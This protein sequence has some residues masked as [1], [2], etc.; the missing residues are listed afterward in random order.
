M[1]SK[2]INRHYLI[3]TRKIIK[4][5]LLLDNLKNFR[6]YSDNIFP[7]INGNIQ[8]L[9]TNRFDFYK[10]CLQ[11]ITS[12]DGLIQIT[13]EDIKNEIKKNEVISGY[14]KF[15]KVKKDNVEDD[16]SY[17]YVLLTEKDIKKIID[18]VD[19]KMLENKFI[20]NGFEQYM[21]DKE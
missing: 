10:S 9:P 3:A 14:V 6:S 8:T 17:K 4:D 18:K 13:V 5:I 12:G 16:D 2:K 15:V 1:L 7:I 11:S 20:K 21:K 19:I